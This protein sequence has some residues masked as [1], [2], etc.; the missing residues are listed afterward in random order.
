VL[1]AGAAGAGC[2]GD[3]AASLRGGNV[4]AALPVG[5]HV[6]R[7]TVPAG[8]RY[9]AYRFEI[10]DGGESR[11]CLAGQDCPIG[12]VRWPVNPVLVRRP[13]G[14]LV[15]APFEVGASDRERRVVLTVY[16]ATGRR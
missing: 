5:C 13:E 12:A 9:T 14:T 10:Q 16:Y 6:L 1:P 8:T 3:I 15:L 7:L 11:D 2:G 4:P